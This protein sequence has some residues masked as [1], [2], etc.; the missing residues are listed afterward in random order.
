MEVKNGKKKE[1][2]KEA[3]PFINCGRP[4]EILALQKFNPLVMSLI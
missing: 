3:V 2:K 1:K 4:F